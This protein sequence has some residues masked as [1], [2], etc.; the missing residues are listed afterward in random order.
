MGSENTPPI[1]AGGCGFYGSAENR[2]LCSKCYKNHLLKELIPKASSAPDKTADSAEKITKST[3][4]AA[5]SSS[6]S[7]SGFDR[8]QLPLRESLLRDAPLPQRALLQLRF[9]GF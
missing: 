3:T 4:P 1:C 9:Q 5:V 2:N 6:S 8:V 7:S